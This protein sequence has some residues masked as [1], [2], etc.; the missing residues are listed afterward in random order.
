LGVNSNV[1][2]GH[3]VSTALAFK[4]MLLLSKDVVDAKLNDKIT[5]IFQ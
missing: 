4:N 3:G 2:I 5:Q 1:L